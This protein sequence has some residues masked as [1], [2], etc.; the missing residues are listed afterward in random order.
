MATAY[1]VEPLRES[2][3]PE[4]GRLARA[5]WRGHYTTIIGA[6]QVEYMLQEKYTLDD[7][8]PCLS[9]AERWFDVLRVNGELAGFLRCS[10]HS[11]EALKL[12]EIYLAS[13]H[14][15]TG[16]GKVLLLR[17]EELA[18]ENGLG[19]VFLYVNRG[20]L[21]S[22]AAYR[23]SGFVVTERKVIDIG[24]GFVMD[25]YRMEQVLT[26]AQ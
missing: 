22:V 12:E 19:T 9:A 4:I 11:S 17:A 16:L 18:R 3:I 21:N 6:A 24:S 15:G 2:E 1:T 10:K 20:N 8:K 7:L 14:R 23:R 26:P 5:I 25:D 13:E